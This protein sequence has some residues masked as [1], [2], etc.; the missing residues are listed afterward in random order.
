MKK[1]I[2]IGGGL[3]LAWYIYQSQSFGKFVKARFAGIKFNLSRTQQNIFTQL[4]FDVGLQIANPTALA[5]N[6]RAVSLDVIYNGKKIGNVEILGEKSLKAFSENFVSVPASVPTFAIFSSVQSAIKAIQDKK[7]II[8][9]VRGVIS[10][11]G[12]NV[13]VNENLQ[14]L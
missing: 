7:P 6:L 2:L 13:E 8:V 12:G 3:L 11:S 14:L 5:V 4:W 1:A 10:T 9:N